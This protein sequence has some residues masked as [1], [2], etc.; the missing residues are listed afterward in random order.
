MHCDSIHKT[1]GAVIFIDEEYSKEADAVRLCR[2][3][4]PRRAR[5]AKR[6]PSISL[7]LSRTVEPDCILKWLE[8]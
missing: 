8:E 7:M 6:F 5:R 2:A 3:R 4:P 1:R